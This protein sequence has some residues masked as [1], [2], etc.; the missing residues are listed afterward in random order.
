MTSQQQQGW[1]LI[2]NTPNTVFGGDDD[3]YTFNGRGVKFG[4]E[5][6]CEGREMKFPHS[7]VRA[8]GPL[9]TKVLWRTPVFD[10]KFPRALSTQVGSEG[11]SR[12]VEGSPSSGVWLRDHCQCKTCVHPITKQRTLNTSQGWCGLEGGSINLTILFKRLLTRSH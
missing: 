1:L 2:Y 4:D 3:H 9:R 7:H 8:V 6:C 10:R 11:V 12:G 5:F